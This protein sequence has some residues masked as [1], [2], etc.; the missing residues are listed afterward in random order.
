MHGTH[1]AGI[2]V[3]AD[4]HINDGVTG[5]APDCLL[6]PVQVFD[7]ERT[8]TFALATGIP[9]NPTFPYMLIRV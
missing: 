4:T 5:V 8:T 2:A 6:M 7:G 1:V 3:G 9:R